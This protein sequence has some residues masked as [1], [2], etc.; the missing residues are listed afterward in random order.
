[1]SSQRFVAPKPRRLVGGRI[2]PVFVGAVVLS[3]NVATPAAAAEAGKPVARLVSP[4]RIL[5]RR[6]AP[7]KPWQVAK[8]GD[9][10]AAGDLLLGAAGP[11]LDGKNGAIR[12]SLH[13]N[14]DGGAR[15]PI[16]ESAVILHEPSDTDLD[17]TLDRGRID[18]VNRKEKGPATARVRVRA[19]SWDVVL[20]DPGSQVSFEV[21]GRWPR[22]AKFSRKPDP[23]NVP[24]SELVVLVLKGEIDLTHEGVVYAMK[25]PPGPALVHW[26]SATGQE[27]APKQLDELPDWAAAPRTDDPDTKARLAAAA[28]LR[29]SLAEQP[30]VEVL[31]RFLNSDDEAHRRLAVFALAALDDLLDLAKAVTTTKY[32]DVLDN[33]VLALRHWI[34]RGP[35]QDIRLFD[36]LVK[37]AH[38]SPAHADIFVELLHSFGEDDLARPETYETLIDYL[39]HERPGIRYLAHWHLVRLVPKGRKIDFKP[40]DPP[41]K[42]RQAIEEWKKL[43]PAGQVPARDD[44]DRKADG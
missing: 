15:Y 10:L 37:E 32:P 1:M 33:G 9:E 36:G 5:L 21:Y 28:D 35:G 17:F 26:D 29:R 7:G 12:L 6:E 4:D 23:Q 30:P 22:G 18:L 16:R 14:I 8:E 44:G 20:E 39:D 41:E 40:F 38:F 24:V 13:S 3:I 25:A 11:A 42:L 43:V 19:G 2:L 31:K 27:D 34:G